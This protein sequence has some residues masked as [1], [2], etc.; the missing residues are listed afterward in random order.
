MS[1]KAKAKAAAEKEASDMAALEQA[2]VSDDVPEGIQPMLWLA[3]KHITK[4]TT[5]TTERLD[6]LEMKTK[7][8]EESCTNRDDDIE[9]LQESVKVL[10]AQFTRSST[11]Q[12]QLVNDIED[13]K[14]RSM[15]DNIIINLD[16]TV[17]DY[18]E[19]KGENCAELVRS[20]LLKTLGITKVYISSAH[21]LSKPVHGKTRPM[22][23][24]IPNSEDRATIFKNAYRLKDTKHYIS[25]Q[26]P[27]SRAERRQF[28]MAEYK[29]KKTDDQNRASLVQDK[30]Y[31]KGK[32]QTQFTKS[33]L[34]ESN[35]PPSK[36]ELDVKESRDIKDGGSVFR[37]YF[38]DA[39]DMHD[40]SN[41]KQF[42]ICKP[43]VASASHLILAYRM[44]RKG[45]KI[46]E[47]FDS[48]R[49]WGTGFRLLKM[50]R[51]NDIIGVC[52]ATR[53]C[54]PG[55]VHIGHKRF[56]HIGDLCLEAYE[57]NDED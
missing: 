10:Q 1:K 52:F 7:A 41:I 34:P 25:Q 42:L 4:N 9:D 56:E 12:G 39:T 51:E 19:A 45:G 20:F 33:A 27:P 29:D 26:M 47:N 53:L 17:T 11:L 46:V 23:A 28:A 18:R 30:L 6:V 13:I 22:I 43:E 38:A 21:R 16:H 2:L 55:Y 3:I 48:D 57:Q 44:E 14:S 32:L 54:S 40:V 35:T 24:R 8:L 49:D 31:V 50:M 36:L 5:N 15:K 37:G